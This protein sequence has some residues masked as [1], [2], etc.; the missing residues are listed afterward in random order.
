MPVIYEYLGIIISFWSNE[1]QPVHVHAMYG[2]A[3]VKVS[4]YVENGMITTIKY[5]EEQG[6]FNA[7]KLRQLKEFISVYKYAILYAWQQKF[8]E[9]VA[10]KK[11]VITKKIKSNDKEG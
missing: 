11:V 4:F 8:I 7:A 2:G 1:H 6:S 10:V 3:I 5:K 9:N